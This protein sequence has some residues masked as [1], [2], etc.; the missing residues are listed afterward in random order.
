MKGIGISGFC[1]NIAIIS[2]EVK[3]GEEG[4]VFMYNCIDLNGEILSNKW[5]EDIYRV[6]GIHYGVDAKRVEE[7][8]NAIFSKEEQRCDLYKINSDK[9]I[10]LIAN[11]RELL[12]Q[13]DNVDAPA[14]HWG[15]CCKDDKVL[16]KKKSYN[17]VN[18]FSYSDANTSINVNVDHGESI[19]FY[20][21]IDRAI[22]CDSINNVYLINSKGQVISNI[23]LSIPALK[24][25]L[26]R[27]DYTYTLFI[28][29][30]FNGLFVLYADKFYLIDINGSIIKTMKE[31]PDSIECFADNQ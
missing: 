15:H 6:N 13:I 16:L 2:K 24:S 25:N 31:Y 23:S 27:E 1:N 5:F 9:T 30:Y 20:K 12:K 17:S 4:V 3:I 28:K 19:I 14:C 10:E 8:K 21:K 26:T 7:D 22:I 29:D 18:N 11:K